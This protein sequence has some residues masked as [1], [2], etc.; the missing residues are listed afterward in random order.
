MAVFR[1]HK[2]VDF[3]TVSTHHLRNKE[4]GLKAKGLLTLMLSLPDDWDYSV[5]GL[6]A[7]S[8]DGK[9][10]VMN[11]LDELSKAGYISIESFRNEKGQYESVYNVYENPNRENR[12]GKSESDNQPQYNIINKDNNIIPFDTDSKESLSSPKGEDVDK[13]FER[14]WRVYDKKVQREQA[15][16]MWKRLTKAE[17]KEI[18]DK[19][20]LYVLSTPD[21]Q[22]RMNP[23]TYINPA[24]KR[25][26]DELKTEQ[27]KPESHIYE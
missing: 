18:L 11:A 20:A 4:I 7:L 5:M 6:T 19:V 26:R 15:F 25:W 23:A 13:E 24:N 8:K 1:I 2:T 14:F 17:K 22:Y 3:T 27:G 12:C 9:D 21:K 10:A 16:R